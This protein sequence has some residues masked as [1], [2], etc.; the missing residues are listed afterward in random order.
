MTPDEAAVVEWLL[1]HAAVG[2]VTEYRQT[3]AAGLRVVEKGC[4]CGCS[5]LD[6]A[7]RAWGGT[8]RAAIIADALAIYPDGQ[9]AGP[10]LWGG[11]GGIVLLEIYDCHPGASRR[12]PG[13]ADLRSFREGAP[14]PF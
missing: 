7:P 1:G 11:E 6:F 14:E 8:D 10:I 3:P 2:D 13:I 4:T 12:F 9:T 5:S